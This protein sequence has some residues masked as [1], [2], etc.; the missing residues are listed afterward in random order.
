MIGCDERGGK[1]PKAEPP[2]RV[3]LVHMQGTGPDLFLIEQNVADQFARQRFGTLG[4]AGIKDAIAD[5]LNL[6]LVR[7]LTPVLNLTLVRRSI[8]ILCECGTTKHRQ[9]CN[10]QV[11]YPHS[12]PSRFVDASGGRIYY[13]PI[14]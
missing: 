4:V 11:T 6:T 14:S 2:R 13:I 10:A 8:F 9:E 3:A 12:H 1:R 7:T 5:V